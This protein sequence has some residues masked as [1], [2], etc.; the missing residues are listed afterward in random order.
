MTTL[1][2]ALCV[3]LLIV[4]AAVSPA[5]DEPAAVPVGV[6]AVDITPKTPIRLIG[7]AGRKTESEGVVS[8][9]KARALAIGSD[10][11]G[12][13]VLI[14]VD[15]CGVPARVT[16]EV[17]SRLKTKVGLPRERLAV[18]STHTHCG[19]TLSGSLNFMFGGALPP[20]Q[21]AHIDDYTRELTDALEK[22]ALA[23]LADRKPGRLSWARGSVGFAANRRVLKDGKWTGFGVNRAGPVDH[24]VPVL[25]VVDPAGSV[26]AVLVGYAC[27][28]TTLGGDFNK[29][30]GEWA[31]YACDAIEREHPG[32]V[33]LVVI[34]CGADANPEPRRGLDDAKAHGA[35]LAAEVAR[36]LNGPMTPLPGRIAADY[37]QIEL[38]F[39]APPTRDQL[40]A[41]AKKPGPPGYSARVHL[42]QLDSPTGLPKTLT[43]P[44]QSWRFGDALAVV[45]LGGEV[46]VD[47]AIRLNRECDA[48]RLW[49][50]AYT[51][52]VPCYIASK[53]IL[54]EGG[55]E[56]DSS[57]IYYGRPTRLAPEAEDLIVDTVH[58]L[59]PDP[60]DS[61]R[62]P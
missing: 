43:Y 16:S 20:E 21:Q 7:Y 22:A 60:F 5:A 12:P 47:Y 26:R 14:A 40:T 57:M 52:D 34:G 1:R 9:L 6:A 35:A 55:Y 18:S 28:C 51:N 37:R 33:A 42:E 30:C 39:G 23:A 58:A 15:N 61:P 17:A 41:D 27:H 54:Q 3:G 31:G 32:A 56:A 45:F 4:P 38:P 8:P 48:N 19:P 53:R 29:V 46:V 59:L 49:V 13:S 2:T 44:V 50:V 62:R 11:D 24:T 10:A 36:V 25:R